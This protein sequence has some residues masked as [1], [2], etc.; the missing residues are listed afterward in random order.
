[1]CLCEGQ[2]NQLATTAYQ[3][4]QTATSYQL[5]TWI[6][7]WYINEAEMPLVK[8]NAKERKDFFF[9]LNAHIPVSSFLLSGMETQAL[10]L[11]HIAMELYIAQTFR[12][13]WHL[14]NMHIWVCSWTHWPFGMDLC[15]LA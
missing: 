1:M 3:P 10:A 5:T 6:G 15:L 8:S 4:D 14:V 9:K 13:S 7:R 2:S 12:M 11:A